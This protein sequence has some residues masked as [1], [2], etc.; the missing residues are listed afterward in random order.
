MVEGIYRVTFTGMKGSGFGVLLLKG[1]AIAGADVVGATFDG[2]YVERPNNQG[3]VVQVTMRFPAGATPVQTGIPLTQPVSVPVDA[4][5]PNDLG[6][7]NA[8]RVETPLGP[9]NVVFAKIR[10]L[11]E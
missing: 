11:P 10:D 2:S 3:V 5:L 8:V 6:N 1:G 9:V 4:T 7:G